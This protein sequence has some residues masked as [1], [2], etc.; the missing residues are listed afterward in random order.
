[1]IEHELHLF[2]YGVLIDRHRYTAEH[3]AASIDQ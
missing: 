2:R 1:M 3:W